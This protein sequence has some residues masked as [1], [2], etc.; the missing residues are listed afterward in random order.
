[1]PKPVRLRLSRRKGFDLQTAS[2]AANGLAAVTVARPSHWGNLFVI[3]RDGTQ[4]Q[5]VRRYR[6]WLA[7]PAQ[8]A[9]RR[10]ARQALRGKNLACWCPLGTPCHGDVLLA[11]ANR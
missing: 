7:R 11:L 8:K 4:A 1:M 5:C 3:G 6:I 2:H 10:E 9:F